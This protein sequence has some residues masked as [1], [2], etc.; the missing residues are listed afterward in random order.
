VLEHFY[1]VETLEE[2][3]AEGAPDYYCDHPRNMPDSIQP[4]CLK[5]SD[6]LLH[7]AA[8]AFGLEV[9]ILPVVSRSGFESYELTTPS[10]AMSSGP[11][12]PS[13]VA[14]TRGF[15]ADP[16][17]ILRCSEMNYHDFCEDVSKMPEYKKKEV[18]A[19]CAEISGGLLWIKLPGKQHLKY[20]GPALDYEGNSSCS[21]CFYAAA[22][23]LVVVPPVGSL[24][25]QG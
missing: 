7:R 25:R 15:K 1:A 4:E 13:D 12:S 16:A 3:L 17:P 23:L 21:T 6:L 20:C 24:A 22:A 11:L 2:C 5:G 10:L 8:R 9:Q 14:V 19:C 18:E